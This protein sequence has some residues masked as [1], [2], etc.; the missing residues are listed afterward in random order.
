MQQGTLVTVE[1]IFSRVPA[2]RKFM[3][4]AQAE[5]RVC[6][7]LIET[8]AVI[9]PQLSLQLFHNEKQVL[10]CIPQSLKERLAEVWGA[11]YKN[12]L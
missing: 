5:Y 7:K 12:G 2:R 10:N 4:T 9:F 3:K 8:Y 6:L 11:Q 1:N